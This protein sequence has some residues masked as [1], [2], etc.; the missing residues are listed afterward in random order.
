LALD[1]LEHLVQSLENFEMKKTLVAL[2]ALAAT[3][4]FAQSSVTISGNVDV[5]MRSTKETATI[6]NETAT[7]KTYGPV[8]NNA[9]TWTSSALKITVAEDMG[10]GMGAGFVG[11]M[12]MNPWNGDAAPQDTLLSNQ[13]QSFVYLKG[14]FGETRVGYQYTLEDQ[15][16]GGVGRNTPTGNTGGRIQNFA[17]AAQTDEAGA[18]FAGA[19]ANN[20]TVRANAI[21]YATPVMSGF[22]GLVQYAKQTNTVDFTGSAAEGK[23]AAT[24]AD[25]AAFAVKYSQGPLNLGL[26]QTAITTH[27]QTINNAAT[28]A[29]VKN[30]N[31]NFAAN[32]DLGTAKLFANMFTRKQ[33]NSGNA[34]VATTGDTAKRTGYDLGVSVPM[35]KWTLFGNYGK[36]KF[37]FFDISGNDNFDGNLKAHQLAATYD[38]SKR[39]SITAYYSVNKATGTA[40]LEGTSY[41]RTVTGAS[42]RHQF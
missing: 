14:G 38:F 1:V 28:N 7:L 9:S 34:A 26:S 40:D 18:A 29:D 19:L 15:I 21:E 13:R 22:Q 5:G 24:N 20:A 6:G 3:S 32:Y 8:G 35:G 31:T 25:L 36:G 2:A 23:A 11:E 37:K 41:K 4:A 10:G 33:T 27:A 16:Q 39:T 12:N 42:L 17:F 30:K